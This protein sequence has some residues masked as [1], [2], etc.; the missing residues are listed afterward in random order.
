MKAKKS[1][2]RPG[3]KKKKPLKKSD[4]YPFKHAIKPPRELFGEVTVRMGFVTK[5]EVNAAL[6]V[7]R[8]LQKKRRKHKLIG[9]IMLEMGILSTTQLISILK[10]LEIKERV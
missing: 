6:T 4:I 2:G 5:A 9:L 1:K 7:Q 3:R 10:E 8:E